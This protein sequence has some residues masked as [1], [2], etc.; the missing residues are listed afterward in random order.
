MPNTLAIDIGGTKFTV[1]LFTDG[2][3]RQRVSTATDREGGRDWMLARI[4]ESVRS[5]NVNLHNCGIGFGGPVDYDN[6]RVYLSTH[7][8]GWEN[9]D[10]IGWVRQTFAIPAVMD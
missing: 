5:W 6:Q 7:V 4:E 3:M 8:G 10:L 9:T 1:A 2:V